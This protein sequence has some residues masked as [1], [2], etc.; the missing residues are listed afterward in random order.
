MKI[1]KLKINKRILFPVGFSLLVLAACTKKLD[2]NTTDT[3]GLSLSTLTAGDLFS[4][5]LLT[6]VTNK[7]GANFTAFPGD[8]YDFA[9]EWMGYWSRNYGDSASG[10]RPEIKTFTI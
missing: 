1:M 5:A 7:V 2:T 3:N 4:Q 10:L 8:N 9:Q 6:T